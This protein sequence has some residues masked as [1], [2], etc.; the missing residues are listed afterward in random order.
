MGRVISVVTHIG[1]RQ[2]YFKLLHHDPPVDRI[3]QFDGQFWIFFSKQT[4][5]SQEIVHY[6]DIISGQIFLLY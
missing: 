2:T 1:S 4:T 3:D 6:G 5:H